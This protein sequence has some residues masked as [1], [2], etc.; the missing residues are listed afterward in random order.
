[1]P[2]QQIHQLNLSIFEMQ[3]LKGQ[4]VNINLLQQ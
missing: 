3:F 2:S 4:G 1:M